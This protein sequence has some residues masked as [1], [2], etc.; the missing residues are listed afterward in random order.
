MDTFIELACSI[1]KIRKQ[2]DPNAL[3]RPASLCLRV[4]FRRGA[5]SHLE[6]DVDG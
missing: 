3:Q 6:K 2:R 1:G 4:R 5:V